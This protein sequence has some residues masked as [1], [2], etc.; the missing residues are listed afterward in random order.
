[1][2]LARRID[3]DADP[4]SRASGRIVCGTIGDRHLSIGVTQQRKVETV[5]LGERCVVGR[6]VEADT[7]DRGVLF[8]IG[9]F[10]VAEPATLGRSPRRVGNR[11]E[12]QNEDLS[13]EVGELNAMAVVIFR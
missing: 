12:T 8:G 9:L 11:V 5:F 6:R 13:G 1:M 10:E 2:D 3:D 7:D 4:S